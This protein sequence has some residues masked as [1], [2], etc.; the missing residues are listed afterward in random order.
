MPRL[1][2]RLELGHRAHGILLPH[3]Q[4]VL[5]IG[6]AELEVVHLGAELRRQLVDA[7]SGV[8]FLASHVVEHAQ[9]HLLSLRLGGV[10]EPNAHADAACTHKGL[11]QLV[12]LVGRHDQQVAFRRCD[13]INGVQQARQAD[14]RPGLG[15]RVLGVRIVVVRGGF[16]GNGPFRQPAAASA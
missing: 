7:G 3:Q 5:Q 9:E 15:G 8:E 13:A 4:V 6:G 12:R 16:L 2:P 14:L 11:V 1:A 10:A